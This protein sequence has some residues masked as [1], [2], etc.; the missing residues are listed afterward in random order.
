MNKRTFV[1]K[2]FNLVTYILGA[3]L[4]ITSICYCLFNILVTGQYEDKVLIF[5]SVLV[6][7]IVAFLVFCAYSFKDIIIKPKEDAK[8]ETKEMEYDPKE[9]YVL[10]TIVIS[11]FDYGMGACRRRLKKYYLAQ[12][13]DDCYYELF[14]KVRV[15]QGPIKHWNA[16]YVKKAELLEVYIKE[17]DFKLSAEFL[18][19]FI[20]K[21]NT[22]SQMQFLKNEYDR[23]ADDGK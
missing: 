6:G 16:P 22:D 23:Y 15:D 7:Y 11:D 14:S 4:I 3:V 19:L 18:F 10:S 12:K 20:T 21:M 8:Q 1:S 2:K 13:K 5:L 9:I 17:V